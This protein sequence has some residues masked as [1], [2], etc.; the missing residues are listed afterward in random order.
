MTDKKK[1]TVRRR[2]VIEY[3]RDVEADS[4][5]EARKAVYKRHVLDTKPHNVA[6]IEDKWDLVEVEDDR[7]RN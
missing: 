4:E 6:V 1:Y 3:F 7:T 2:L 5:E